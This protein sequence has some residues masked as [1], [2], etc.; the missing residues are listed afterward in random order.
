[1]RSYFIR[2]IVLLTVVEFSQLEQL[3]MKIGKSGRKKESLHIFLTSNGENNSIA[4]HNIVLDRIISELTVSA[5]LRSSSSI[6]KLA[7]LV[8]TVQVVHGY[9]SDHDRGSERTQAYQ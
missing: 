1:V 8:S 5:F 9:L 4:S 7:I 2:P 3:A 6:F